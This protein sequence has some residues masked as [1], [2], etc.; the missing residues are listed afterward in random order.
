MRNENDYQNHSTEIL[1]P[2]LSN[3]SYLIVASLKNDESTFAFSS[4][5]I[6]NLALVETES[7]EN[8]TLQIID[9]NHGKPISNAL[10]ELSYYENNFLQ[11]KKSSYSV[12]DY[13]FVLY[14]KYF[15][16]T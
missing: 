4:I 7:E 12:Y 2:K 5:Q 3:G 11:F 6:T 10:V 8:K 1:V 9:R 13:E 16:T 14:G 15:C